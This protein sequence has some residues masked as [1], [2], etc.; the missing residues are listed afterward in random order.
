MQRSRRTWLTQTS[1]L[2]L[3]A[4]AAAAGLPGLARAQDSFP[5]RPI[6]LLSLI[7]I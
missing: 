2:G 5:S 4:L 6:T 1:A 7:H 3:T